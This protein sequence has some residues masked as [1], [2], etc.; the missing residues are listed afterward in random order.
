MKL[1]ILLLV[2]GGFI[3]SYQET[4]SI[5]E[6]KDKIID[7]LIIENESNKYIIDSLKQEFNTR[8]VLGDK[9]Y[10]KYNKHN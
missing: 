10:Y 5:I 7:N 8:E 1:V 6:Y 3:W 4:I 9:L 2:I